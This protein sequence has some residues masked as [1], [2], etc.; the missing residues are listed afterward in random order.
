MK[1]SDRKL[2]PKASWA[3]YLGDALP[4]SAGSSANRASGLPALAAGLGAGVDAGFG[5]SPAGIRSGAE[6]EATVAAG[7]GAAEAAAGS[8][9]A[10]IRRASSWAK[11]ANFG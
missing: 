2:Y 6:A 8:C 9:F 11:P 1:M 4:G 7:A 5:V 3:T 10:A